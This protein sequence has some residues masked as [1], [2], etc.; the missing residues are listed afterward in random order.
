MTIVTPEFWQI[1]SGIFDV[2]YESTLI[3]WRQKVLHNRVRPTS[4][5]RELF[6]NE[7]ITTYGG[8]T[9]SFNF[10]SIGCCGDKQK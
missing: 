7:D 2:A 8:A 4:I 9:V 5:V 6:E 1:Q 3:V 10:I